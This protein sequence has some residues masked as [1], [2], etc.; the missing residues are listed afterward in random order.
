MSTF[1]KKYY[2][3]KN[4]EMFLSLSW[5]TG[6][7]NIQ[8]FHENRLVHTI[9]QPAVLIKGIKIQDEELGNLKFSFTTERPRK[10]VIKVNN[11]KFKTINKLD[12]GYDYTGLITIFT[13]LAVLAA[14]ESLIFGGMFDFDFSYPLFSFTFFASFA[15]AALYGVTSYLLSKKKSW[16]YFMGTSVFALTTLM[17]TIGISIILSSFANVILLIPRFGMLIYILLQIKH[18]LKEMKKTNASN[19]GD[20]LIDSV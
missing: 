16:S 7:R 14:M 8:V 3:P 18:I 1:S 20:V 17:S 10:L 2:S 9:H 13:S 4:P 19:Q 11:R 6:Y 12:L 5:E 15:I